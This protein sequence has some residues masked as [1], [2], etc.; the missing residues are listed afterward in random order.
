MIS[1]RRALSWC[2]VGGVLL[3]LGIALPGRVIEA[4]SRQDAVV[5]RYAKD[6]PTAWGE[7]LEGV[8]S[9]LA[10]AERVLMAVRR[11]EGV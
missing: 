8:R 10:T 7:R 3:V 1:R 2:G 9:R 4:L 11:V 6:L 5:A